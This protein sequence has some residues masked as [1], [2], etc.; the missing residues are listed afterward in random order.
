[1]QAQAAA[2]RSVQSSSADAPAAAAWWVC[3]RPVAPIWAI[4]MCRCHYRVDAFTSQQSMTFWNPF[5]RYSPG[6]GLTSGLFH[7]DGNAAIFVQNSPVYRAPPQVA[8]PSYRCATQ[9][10][11][12]VANHDGNMQF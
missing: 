6:P 1:M 11:T 10:L 9:I 4:A 8:L 5:R 7:S 3:Q 2:R 12:A